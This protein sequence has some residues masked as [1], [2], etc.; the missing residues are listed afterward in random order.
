MASRK[1]A[2]NEVAEL[3][4]LCAQ[5]RAIRQDKFFGLF[6][7]KGR[8]ERRQAK[9]VGKSLR[10]RIASRCDKLHHGQQVVDLWV[11]HAERNQTGR[12]QLLDGLLGVKAENLIADFGSRKR[13][14]EN[15]LIIGRLQ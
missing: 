6:I 8:R 13:G 2:L 15:I 1:T 10:Q 5:C 7:S 12:E 14:V 3:R 4:D 9:K 11:V